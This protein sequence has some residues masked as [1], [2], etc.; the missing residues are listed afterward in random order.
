MLKDQ[1][2]IDHTRRDPDLERQDQKMQKASGV[3]GEGNPVPAQNNQGRKKRQSRATK[4][5]ISITKPMLGISAG[6]SASVGVE[7]RGL[8]L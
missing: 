6:E 4:A 8:L 7:D 2:G 1:C 3:A 5:K